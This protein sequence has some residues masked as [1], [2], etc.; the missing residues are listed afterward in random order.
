M[1][2]SGC[3]GYTAGAGAGDETDLQQVR[4]DNVL[5]SVAFLAE[6]GGEGLDA[7]GT[8]VISGHQASQISTVEIVKSQFVY[9]LDTQGG[10][11]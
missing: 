1:T 11:G 2:V 10:I 4:F 7:G 5:K 8:A 6:A 3:G 9:F